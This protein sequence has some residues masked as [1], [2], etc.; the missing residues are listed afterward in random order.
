MIDKKITN[1]KYSKF[2]K[3]KK[4]NSEAFFY[5]YKALELRDII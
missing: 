3:F 4:T 2:N 1:T 5:W